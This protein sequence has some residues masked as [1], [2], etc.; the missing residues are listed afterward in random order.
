MSGSFPLR[1]ANPAVACTRSRAAFNN[2]LS[3]RNNKQEIAVDV[4]N[5]EQVNESRRTREARLITTERY[6]GT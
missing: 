6:L 4:K 3:Y 5:D 2:I 1:Y